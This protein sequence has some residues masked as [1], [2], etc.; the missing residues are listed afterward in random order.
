MSKATKRR[1]QSAPAASQ[2]PEVWM[3]EPGDFAWLPER[4]YQELW[5]ELRSW[6]WKSLAIVPT[7]LRTSEFDVAER[8]IVVGVTNT[9]RR[10]TLISAEGV[11]VGETDNVIGLIREAE[12]RGDRVIVITDSIADNP[13]STPIV[14]SVN[15]V[16]PVVRLGSSDRA[17]VDRTVQ[18][19]GAQ[20]VIGVVTR[21]A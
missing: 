14:R 4:P 21:D 2:S 8:V 9:N 7:A 19:V 11:S 18:T 6:A 15:G 12:A 10:M 16:V 17:S 20:R 3:C 5:F 13:A 1:D